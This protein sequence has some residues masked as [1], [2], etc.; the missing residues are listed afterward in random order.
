MIDRDETNKPPSVIAWF[1]Q[2]EI[3]YTQCE[4]QASSIGKSK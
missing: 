1:V 2:V 4:E 3:G